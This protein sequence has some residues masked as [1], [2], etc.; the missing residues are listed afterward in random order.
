[1]NL[2]ELVTGTFR[3]E[4]MMLIVTAG[5]FLGLTEAG[6]RRGLR[7]FHNHDTARRDQIGPIQAAVLGL[8]ALLIGFTFS[9]AVERFDTRRDLVLQEANAIGT[10]YLRATFL[11]PEQRTAVEDLLRQYVE[12]RLDFYKAGRDMDA[13][14]AV[15]GRA[16]RLQTEMWTQ[17]GTAAKVAPSPLTVSFAD[18]LNGMIDLD[19]TRLYTMH[20]HVPGA[21]WLLLMLVAGVGCY[22]SGCGAGACDARNKLSNVG[23]PLLIAVVITLI[24]DLDSPYRGF[25]RL[26]QQP[27]MNLKASMAKPAN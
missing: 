2:D 18:A 9:M 21:V 3:S 7:L 15:E 25:I 5:L 4:W 11:P 19:A 16:A 22:A 24:A 1:M 12:T 17:T 23:L 10:T 6:F 13:V 20:S 26:D 27:M 8:L 14:T